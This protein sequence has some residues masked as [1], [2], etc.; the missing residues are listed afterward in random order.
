[1]DDGAGG[2]MEVRS[3]GKGGGI[4]PRAGVGN[5]RAAGGGMDGDIRGSLAITGGGAGGSV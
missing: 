2:K 3:A 1:M 4:E 5:A